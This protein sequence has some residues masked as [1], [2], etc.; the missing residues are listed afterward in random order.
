VFSTLLPS[1]AFRVTPEAAHTL[2]GI[3]R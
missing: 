3:E 2:Y 1:L